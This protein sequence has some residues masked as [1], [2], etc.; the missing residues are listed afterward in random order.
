MYIYV[1]PGVTYSCK[2]LCECWELNPDPLEEQSVLLTAEPPPVSRT[3]SLKL[4][5]HICVCEVVFN[6]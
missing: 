3:V 6:K 2:P 4:Y 5:I 1:G